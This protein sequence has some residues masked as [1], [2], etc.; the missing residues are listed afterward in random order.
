MMDAKSRSVVLD[1]R[2]FLKLCA[3][4]GTIVGFGSLQCGSGIEKALAPH[5][6]RFE[7]PPSLARPFVRWWWNGNRIDADELA[8]E[9]VLMKEAGFGGVEINPI[10]LNKAVQEPGERAVDWLSPEWNEL[11]IKSIDKA[12]SVDMITDLIVGTGWPFGGQ[13]IN[14]TETLQGIQTE[15]IK[16]HGPTVFKHQF[17]SKDGS[18]TRLVNAVLYRQPTTSLADGVSLLDRISADGSLEIEISRGEYLLVSLTWRNHFREV[19]HGAPGGDGPVLDHFNATAVKKY[20]NNMSDKLNPLFEGALGTRIRS[21]FCDS[22]EL[23]GANWT[24]DFSEQFSE[25]NGYEIEPFLPLV[26]TSD[27]ELD[28]QMAYTVARVRYDYSKTLADLL[29][30]RFIKVFHQWCQDNQVKSRYQAYGYP[31]LYT[32]LLDGYL[33]PDIPEGDQWLFNRGWVHGAEIDAIRYA[34][35]NKYA[36]SGGHLMDRPVISSEAMTNT[37]GVFRTSLEYIKQATDLNIVTGINQLI[38]HGFNYSPPTAEYPGWIRFGTFFNEQNPWWPCVSLWSDYTA[39][40]CT[41]FQNAKT[42]NHI[43][44]M[45]PTPDV[46]REHGL[47]RNPWTTSP[48]YIHELWQAFNHYG[49]GC[50]Y[51]NQTILNDAEFDGGLV[52][53]PMKYQV[54][55]LVDAESI[56]PESAEKL[57]DYVQ[58]GGRLIFIDRVPNQAPG[59]ANAESND[60]RVRGA[61]A[62]ITNHERVAV[63]ASP[64]SGRVTPWAGAQIRRMEVELNVR[65]SNPDERLFCI[66]KRLDETPVVFF[67]NLDRQRVIEFDAEFPF[68]TQKAWQWDP[69][70]GTR[71]PYPLQT[72]HTCKVT[73]EPL[74]SLLLVFENDSKADTVPPVWQSGRTIKDIKGPWQVELHPIRG[75]ARTLDMSELTDLSRLPETVHF[76]GQAIYK[77]RFVVEKEQ[78][79]YLDLGQVHEI[80]TVT[81]DGT[82]MGTRW[83]GKR[84][85]LIAE[86]L[87]RGE[88][89]LTIRVSTLMW[90]DI[91]GVDNSM[92][93]FWLDRSNV[94]DPLPSGL[95]GPVQLVQANRV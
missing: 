61:L 41:L 11:L 54:L 32:D 1:R 92:T 75:Q 23:E 83:Y 44:I 19:M 31:W 66:E 47:D 7:S 33:I 94:K 38:V 79:V 40:L 95:V 24:D 5:Y 64:E 57:R 37:R 2:Q 25:R 17:A 36:S 90:N 28:M 6:K 82:E 18:D 15:S 53:G 58:A 22:I 56:S 67:A 8:R 81:L 35:W 30:E 76:A 87:G 14:D 85:F 73:L 20:L 9:L 39:R 70:S 27:V 74:Q 60:R 13:F 55:I 62:G 51:V 43:A 77:T 4:S 46:W 80:A 16:I 26:L 34:I 89:E 49:C 88:H 59:Y 63:V 10:E 91:L 3:L 21:M 68:W 72:G 45:G 48:D 65:I 71:Q 86:G 69:E 42:I 29:T 12:D 52:Y 78:P 50:D 93:K 84:R